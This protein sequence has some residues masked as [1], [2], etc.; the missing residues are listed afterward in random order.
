MP[1]INLTVVDGVTMPRLAG[2]E[3]LMNYVL[4]LNLKSTNGKVSEDAT[5]QDAKGVER[6]TFHYRGIIF[7]SDDRREDNRTLQTGFTSKKD[8]SIPE[9]R[10][11]AMGLGAKSDDGSIGGWGATGHS[12]VS[13]AKHVGG[14]IDHVNETGTFYIIDTTKLPKNEKAWDM[15]NTVYQ[16]GYKKRAGRGGRNG[17]RSERFL[18]PAQRH[19]RRNL[20]HPGLQ[21][22]L[23]E[24]RRTPPGHPESA[25]ELLVQPRLQAV[26]RG[27]KPPN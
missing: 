26:N 8:L 3:D 4:S 19:R 22:L 21:H 17:R 24:G 15:E 18:H 20:H 14:A 12:G 1:D 27:S 10:T 13:C 23:Q 7:R 25:R 2:K 16:N 9:N 5:A 6:K 11:E